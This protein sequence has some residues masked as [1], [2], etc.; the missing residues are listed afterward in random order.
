MTRE[1]FDKEIQ[2]CDLEDDISE[3][4]YLFEVASKKYISILEAKIKTLEVPKTCDECV[5]KPLQ[6]ENYM[7]PCE[8]C[9]QFYSDYYEA[10]ENKQN[11]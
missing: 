4:F 11:D 7:E 6:G 10:K 1:E 5:H 3:C 8:Q 9:K 2:E